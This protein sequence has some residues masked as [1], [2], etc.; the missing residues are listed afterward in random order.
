[1][2]YFHI[3]SDCLVSP[4]GME[5]M[6]TQ[7]RTQSG[8]TCQRWDSQYPHHHTFINADRFPEPTLHDAHNYCRNPD[9]EPG[10]PWCYTNDPR[11]RWRYCDVTLCSKWL[12]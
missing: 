4:T 5:Y 12:T 3:P 9:L 8:F 1:M 6:G 11:H 10:G 7:N 2:L